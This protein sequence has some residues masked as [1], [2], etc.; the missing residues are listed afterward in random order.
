MWPNF[1]LLGEDMIPFSLKLYLIFPIIGAVLCFVAL[2]QQKWMIRGILYLVAGFI[3]YLISLSLQGEA[4]LMGR[5]MTT[6][7]MGMGATG[8]LTG[9]LGIAFTVGLLALISASFIGGVNRQNRFAPWIA[10]GG[11][12]L[13]A[14]SL[15]I[16][17]DV[18]G[19][20][21]ANI[22][23]SPIWAIG[24]GEIFI[25][26]ILLIFVVCM[27]IAAV[28]GILWGVKAAQ[29]ANKSSII[30]LVLRIG[31]IQL[32][33]FGV[34]GMLFNGGRGN[35]LEM[36]VF[37]VPAILKGV[38]MIVGPFFAKCLGIIELVTWQGNTTPPAGG[39]ST[40]LKVEAPQDGTPFS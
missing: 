38:G 27:V 32:L 21:F 18:P 15:L 5:T 11:G 20:G 12:C 8:V 39:D 40:V 7:G 22:L 36:L 2:A 24:E 9:F 19:N 35:F 13:L 1:E 17:I 34:L 10:L 37:I 25:G 14:L 28:N 26:I 33:V 6:G 31:F 30:K 3:P 16:P 4:L 23:I 29:G